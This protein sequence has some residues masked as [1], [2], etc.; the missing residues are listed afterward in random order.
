[1]PTTPDPTPAA[2]VAGV[3]DDEPIYEQMAQLAHEIEEDDVAERLIRLSA[4]VRRRSRYAETLDRWAAQHVPDG[5]RVRSVQIRYD[6]GYDPTF[7][8][9]QAS[10]D[11]VINFVINF[12]GSSHGVVEPDAVTF[13]TS[14]GELLT[15]L[16]A[17]EES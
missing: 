3:P 7:D 5:A 17:I 13:C 11:V 1:M 10:L 14:I 2:A 9:G 8:G 15:E 6:D 12:A 16:F 4:K